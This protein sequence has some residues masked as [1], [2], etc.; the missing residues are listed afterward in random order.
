MA[1]INW[2]SQ[3]LKNVISTSSKIHS[4]INNI[5][6]N[7]KLVKKGDLFIPIKGNRYDGHQ[8]IKDAFKRGAALSIANING[9]KKFKLNKFKTKII[10]VENIQNT[11]NNLA[12][13]SRKRIKGKILAITGSVGKTSV[14]EAISLILKKKMKIQSNDGNFNNLIGMPL[15]LARFKKNI[16]LGILELGMNKKGE[17]K[18][19]S[20]IC[21][22]DIALITR[23]A[24]SHIGNFN[25]LKDIALAKSE[26]F[27]GMNESGTVILNSNDPYSSILQEQAKSLGL[28]KFIFFGKSKKSDVSLL[29]VEHKKNN[30]YIV[31]VDAMGKK[32]NFLLNSLAPHWIEN[33]LGIIAL[34]IL[35]KQDPEI[36]SKEIKN[37][38]AIKGR[39]KILKINLK[40]KKFE[41]IDD[42]YNASPDSIRS[43][44]FF[45]NQY[46]KEKRKICVLGDMYELGK[47]SKKFHL[48]LKKTITDNK[49]FKV[50]TIG[51][52]MKNLHNSL[53]KLIKGK[54][55]KNL[56]E[57][58]LNLEELIETNDVI[59]FKGSRAMNLDK[60]I[61]KF[62][63]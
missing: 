9:Y 30:Q 3:D 33:S 60:V 5:S 12:E 24:N 13:F 46:A 8:F 48:S 56:E 18:K 58:H 11:L 19:L 6:I 4:S 57:L 31:Y 41:I 17:I 21:K 54:H 62:N 61:D 28:K 43:S 52:E 1:S 7:S 63:K 2:K 42:S 26:I 49:I 35:I 23:I 27:S 45:L 20:N 50:C 38:E 37:F 32:I 15:S 55:A 14:K 29:K 25:S 44:L 16:E 40:N 51:K 53:P 34:L 39:G 47:F 59:L 36:F 22:P 10:L